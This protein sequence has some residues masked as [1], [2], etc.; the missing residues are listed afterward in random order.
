MPV[1]RSDIE[2]GLNEL[3]SYEDGGRFQ[4]LAVVL[5]KKRWS[6]LIASERKKDL[7]VDAVCRRSHAID[8]KGKAV[9]C[10]LTPVLEKIQKD[11]R[12]IKQSFSDI[13]LLIFYTPDTVTNY[14]SEKWRPAILREFGFDLLIISRED[15]ILTLMMPENA[16]LCR[17]HLGISVPLD[18]S[19]EQVLSEV[20]GATS[21]EAKAWLMHRRLQDRPM[22]ALTAVRLNESAQPTEERYDLTAIERELCTARRIILEGAAGIGKTTCLTQLANSFCSAGGLAFIVDFPGWISSGDEIL[23]FVAGMR[24]YKARGISSST[25]ARLYDAEHFTF[26]LNGW[27]EIPDGYSHEAVR[28]LVDLER[29][30]PAA[31]IAIATRSHHV[32]PPLPGAIRLKLL[33]ISHALRKSYLNE[34]IG[35]AAGTL[36]EQIANSP[37]LNEMTRTP[38]ILSEVVGL[39]LAGRAIPDTKLGV[40]AAAVR[41]IEESG[42]HG[43]PLAE[44]PIA[45]RAGDYLS[46]LAANLTND[47]K[48]EVLENEARA[49]VAQVGRTLQ[50][51]GQIGGPPEPSTVLNRLCEH[52]VLERI[53]Y[54]NV[55]FRFQHQQFQEFYATLSLRPFSLNLLGTTDSEF[56]RNYLDRPTWE[57]PLCILAEALRAEE[58]LVA[59]RNDALQAAARIIELT[60]PIDPFFASQLVRLSDRS[61]WTK[62]QPAF[63]QRLRDWYHFG[64][65]AHRRC[66]LAAMLE[67]GR[68]EFQDLILPL[69]GSP[70]QRTRLSTYRAGGGFYVSSLGPDW[71]KIVAGW[72]ADARSEF[73][74]ELIDAERSEAVAIARA[75]AADDPDE[76][77]RIAAI[78]ILDWRGAE[79]AVEQLLPSLSDSGFVQA[80]AGTSLS[81]NLPASLR[82]RTLLSYNRLA[83]QSEDPARRIHLLVQAARA[84]DATALARLSREIDE[85]RSDRLSSEIQAQLDLAIEI[86]H[87]TD[88]SSVGEWVGRMFVNGA[89]WG[90][91]WN[92]YIDA[93]PSELEA[94][95][96][97]RLT[98]QIV[99]QRERAAT[100]TVLARISSERVVVLAFERLCRL[101]EKLAHTAREET[102]EIW[103]LHRQVASLLRRCKSVTVIETIASSTDSEIDEP[104]LSAILDVIGEIPVE[105]FPRLEDDT[106]HPRQIV[107][108]YL[109]RAVDFAL[110]S[111]DFGGELK[112]YLATAISRIGVPDDLPDLMRLVESDIVRLRRGRAA[113]MAGDNGPLGQG[114]RTGCATW[115]VRAMVEL[116]PAAVDEYLLRLLDEP[117]YEGE[118]ALALLHLA[119]KAG[120]EPPKNWHWA[121]DFRDGDN[122]SDASDRF[123]EPNRTRYAEAIARKLNTLTTE[124]GN[125]EAAEALIIRMKALA[126]VLASLDGSQSVE[127]VLRTLAL[128]G[129]WDHWVRVDGIEA[130]LRAGAIL[131]AQPTINVLQPVVDHVLKEGVWAQ[132]NAFLLKKCLC[133]LPFVHEPSRGIDEIRKILPQ[134]QIPVYELRDI[135]MAIG[136]SRCADG[137]ALLMELAPKLTDD[138]TIGAWLTA[139]AALDTSAARTV[140]MSFV[141]PDLEAPPFLASLQFRTAEGIAAKIATLARSEK[142]IHDRLFELFD[143]SLPVVKRA[144]LARI[145]GELG[146][147]EA[148]VRGMKLIAD[149]ASPAIPPELIRSVEKTVLERR[150][151]RGSEHTFTL[152]PRGSEALRAELFRMVTTDDARR[153]SAFELLGTI[154]VWRIDEGKP[155]AEPRH[156]NLASGLPWPP[157]EFLAQRA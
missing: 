149:S 28:A 74:H 147:T 27:N 124:L 98:T 75:F 139:I 73:I 96:A 44:P 58:P 35:T 71:R 153:R 12:R 81:D 9:A 21:D 1:L 70:D 63:E 55:A 40:L 77:V 41:V 109:K 94:R 112:R 90:D 2:R 56:R 141:D 143:R 157:L 57:E 26:L 24:P 115:H 18:P 19:T 129:R 138:S 76:S 86:L 51:T 146:T 38:L 155:A 23:D 7:G 134:A 144:L 5:A 31:G 16:S 120:R 100:T 107:R 127:L 84:G 45:G 30:F 151:Y 52:H 108:A 95:L 105:D 46:A 93:I 123:A 64:P 53:E 135:I 156:P 67:T 15:I 43:P 11:A 92:Q 133:L 48:V 85:F 91:R 79:S 4:A 117:E 130:L 32:P 42:E 106:S 60:L 88:P 128:P 125:T 10:S 61:A 119:F 132:Q 14:T 37:A 122:A 80:L 104:K 66:A 33:P 78:R 140:L 126:K 87:A 118:A 54:P 34:V 17:T 62:V 142:M 20:R 101:R 114:G 59:T 8:G 3:R 89:I 25:L 83:D 145:V 99:D 150:P 154:E 136:H 131:P 22:I 47:G 13:D 97:D 36:I 29:S 49:V 152:E 113:L 69:L 68:E 110:G 72:D 137:L 39:Y 103:E 6:D 65:E 148:A 116:A 50:D 111:D 82:E 102:R 121:P